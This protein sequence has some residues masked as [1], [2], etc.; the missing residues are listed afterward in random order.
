[1]KNL[2]FL[3]YSLRLWFQGTLIFLFFNILRV[4][5]YY[6]MLT[7]GM[8]KGESNPISILVKLYRHHEDMRSGNYSKQSTKVFVQTQ[9][10]HRYIPTFY[11]ISLFNGDFFEEKIIR[12][13]CELRMYF[14]LKKIPSYL[15]VVFAGCKFIY[16]T[17]DLWYNILEDR[18]YAICYHFPRTCKF[19]V[20]FVCFAFVIHS[21][22]SNLRA[23]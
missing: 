16:G 11:D 8:D 22:S 20:E 2:N 21:R 13:L 15:K 5:K 1:L 3:L 9:S 19:S 14:R 6:N 17:R 12:W 18:V 10:F 23:F 4:N 7:N